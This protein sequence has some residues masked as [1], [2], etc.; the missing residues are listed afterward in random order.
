MTP[1]GLVSDVVELSGSGLFRKQILRFGT[2][3]YRAPDGSTRT[4][5]FD[6]D[7]G[8]DLVR[9]FKDGAYDQVPF[10]LAG[11]DNR[12]NNNPRNTGGEIVGVELSADGSGLDGLLRLWGEGHR[13]VENNRR[14]GVSARIIENLSQPDGRTYPRALQHVLGTVDPQVAKM[15]PWEKVEL[16]N[17]VEGRCLDLSGYNYGR[18]EMPNDTQT[19]DQPQLS[20]EELTKLRGIIADDEALQALA[21]QLPE[22]FFSDEGEGPDD[23]DDEDSEGTEGADDLVTAGTQTDLSGTGGQALELAQQQ[24]SSQEARIV[25]LTRAQTAANVEVEVERY[26]GRG[27]APAV[28]EDAK[29]LLAVPTGAVELSNGIGDA[30][31]PGEAVR[32]LLNT[33]IDLASSGHLLLDSDDEIGSLSGDKSRQT[34]REAMLAD[35]SENYG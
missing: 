19:E 26:R 1:F 33:V 16:S 23:D 3:E 22:G 18:G 14:L 10:Q 2:I 15:H 28:L 5:K 24:I 11:D 35:W 4:I 29:A 34:E 31:D 9:A 27:L 8:E 17:H 13:A 30:V 6:R 12:H 7:Y 20:E 32:K 21:Q 25:E